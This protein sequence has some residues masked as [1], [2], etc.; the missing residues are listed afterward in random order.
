MADR[1]YLE[2]SEAQGVA[3]KFYEVIID[4]SEVTIR[5]GRIG[6]KGTTQ[7][8]SY[9][10]PEKAK[11]DAGKKIASKRKKGYA[12]AV[13]GE[14]K[15]RAVSRREV[16]STKSTASGAPV[17]WKLETKTTAFGI[18]IDDQ[19]C[20]VGNEAGRVICVNHEGAFQREFKLPD[21]VKCLVADSAWLYAGCDDGNVYDLTGKLPTVAYAIAD[22][23]D[24]YWLDIADAVLGVADALGKVHVFNHE[25]EE[26]WSKKSTGSHGWMVRCDEIGVYH[27][28]SA[29]VTMYDW[30][31]GD[32][33]WHRKTQGNVL[34]GWQEEDSVY[35]GTSSG[36]IHGF[37]KQGEEQVT[38]NCDK[39][40]Y[41]CATAEGGKYIF[42]GDNSSTIYCFDGSGKRLWKMATGCGSA[43]SMQYRN[44]KVFVVTTGGILACIDAS[45]S[46]IKSAQAGKV[47]K[48]K[49]I[50]APT[51]AANV[52]TVDTAVE[53]TRD[54]GD[55]IV[56]E[57]YKKS[58]RIRVRAIS[59]GYKKTWNVQFPKNLRQE[60]AKFVVEELRESSRGGFYRVR[61]NIRRLEE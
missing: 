55:G 11:A 51:Q 43:L 22:D 9:P 13:M 57:C 25:D 12:D 29:G 20:W 36:V 52:A 61:G 6:T 7:K 24:I 19:Q 38:C 54:S 45:E 18:S 56:V 15:K 28:H 1:T 41:S 37:T 26:Q 42:A 10:S 31:G 49:N 27:G 33:I 35:A 34:F 53:T 47:P 39:A 3:H 48:V 21:G 17:L 2:L 5:F 46:A 4:G 60:G 30:D 14:R 32:K 8:K 44:E 58:G 50:K 40:V 16:T 59:S 23:V